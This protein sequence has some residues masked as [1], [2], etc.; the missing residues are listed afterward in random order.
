MFFRSYNMCVLGHIKECVSFREQTEWIT[1]LTAEG[2]HAEFPNKG[3]SE[4]TLK[5]LPCTEHL[6]SIGSWG[7]QG[8]CAPLPPGSFPNPVRSEGRPQ[9]GV[10]TWSREPPLPGLEP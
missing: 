4:S 5:A 1:K 2:G 10:H 9:E 7:Y 8:S 3:R 6:F